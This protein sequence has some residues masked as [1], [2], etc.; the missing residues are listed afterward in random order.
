MSTITRMFLAAV[1]LICLGI[2][3]NMSTALVRMADNSRYLK[4]GDDKYPLIVLFDQRRA[5][6]CTPVSSS[7]DQTVPSCASMR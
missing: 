3:F 6:V 1:I 5:V 7:A 4:L 2:L